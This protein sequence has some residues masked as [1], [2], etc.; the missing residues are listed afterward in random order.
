M[1]VSP[2]LGVRTPKLLGVNLRRQLP[3][4]EQIDDSLAPVAG[5]AKPFLDRDFLGTSI[6]SVVAPRVGSDVLEERQIVGVNAQTVAVGDECCVELFC[7]NRQSASF[8]SA[9]VVR[10][11]SAV[12]PSLV[13]GDRGPAS[14]AFDE[15]AERKFVPVSLVRSDR[16]A[17]TIEEL[18]RD[19]EE[20]LVDDRFEVAAHSRIPRLDHDPSRIEFVAKHRVKRLHRHWLPES[21]PQ[22]QRCQLIQNFA[23]RVQAGGDQFKCL[24]DQRSARRI[25]S[26][27]RFAL[28]ALLDIAKRR[29]ECPSAALDFGP[30]AAEGVVGAIGVVQ[31]GKGG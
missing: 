19:Q 6:G 20:S 28:R 17:A 5:G 15:S 7:T 30:H 24:S 25:E 16:F 8:C 1:L 14:S 23:L 29:A 18:L 10:V 3:V 27:A 26:Q 22:P 11:D 4:D 9:L 12:S 31:F 13:P 21:R 2:D